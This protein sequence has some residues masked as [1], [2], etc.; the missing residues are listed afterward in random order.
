MPPP[1]N[2]AIIGD[3]AAETP[4]SAWAIGGVFLPDTSIQNFIEGIEC[5]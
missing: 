4:T 2:D 5:D 1:V 3:I